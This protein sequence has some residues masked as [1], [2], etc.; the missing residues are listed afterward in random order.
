MKPIIA[1]TMGDPA[2]IGPEV[3]VKA[4]ETGEIYA[5][6][7]PVV[8]GACQWMS[9]A[10]DLFAPSLSISPQNT[11]SQC[12]FLPGKLEVLE[13]TTGRL[14]PIVYGVPHEEGS[15]ASMRAI[16]QAA[17]LALG[18]EVDAIATAPINKEALKKIGFAHPG[19]TEF[20]AHIAHCTAGGVPP[21]FG[22]MMV[23]GGLRIML[24][25]IHLSLRE[26]ILMTRKDLVLEKIRLTHQALKSDFGLPYGKIAVAALNPHA[27]EGGLF[28]DEE[29]TEIH[30]AVLS[31]Q[32]EGIN[33]SGPYPA[34]TLFYRLKQGQFD[35]VVAL[36]HDQALIPIKLLAFGNG[37]NVTV[38]LPFVRTSVHHGTGFDIAGK[39]IAD[40]GSLIQ[41]ITLAAEMSSS[42]RQSQK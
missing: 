42:R 38:G 36:Y 27:G 24:A 28:G 13:I 41:A 29:I 33:V 37:V 4:F 39:G 40:S 2:G 5:V 17:R 1:I 11:I 25:T 19:H 35:A 30:P 8:V 14:P 23:G 20:L 32:A 31:A 10:A 9:H 18:H 12:Q 3:I 7:R 22:M 6:C 34:D 15:K 26:A 16:E 21:N